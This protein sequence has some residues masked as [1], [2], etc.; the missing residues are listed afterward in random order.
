[1]KGRKAAWLWTLVLAAGAVWLL[2]IATASLL[3]LAAGERASAVAEY[4]VSSWGARNRTYRVHYVHFRGGKEYRG[5]GDAV[6][7]LAA[8]SRVPV[9]VLAFAP[10]IHAVDN[11]G[12]L[13]IQGLCSL[14]AGVGLAVVARR[15][16][17]GRART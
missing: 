12:M 6:R 16:I 1:M 10:A 9:R 8:G 17:A 13:A 7:A 15:R 14:I 3:L 4:S 2:W 11:G 5:S